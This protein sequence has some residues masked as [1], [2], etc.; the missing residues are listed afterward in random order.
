MSS[1]QTELTLD[2]VALV[3]S[4]LDRASEIYSRMGF[5]LSPRSSHKGSL[6]PDGPVEP[7]GTGNHCAMFATGYLE[8][9][10]ITDKKR[11]SEHVQV[12]LDEYEGLHLIALGCVEAEAEANNIRHRLGKGAEPY[13]VSRDVPMT[14]GSSKQATFN[15]LQLPDESFP[16]ADLFLIEHRNKDVIWQPDMLSQPNGVVGLSEVIV[17]SDDIQ[18]TAGRLSAALGIS[19]TGS[20]DSL[21]FELAR[22]TIKIITRDA[23]GVLFAGIQPPKLPWVAAVEFLTADTGATGKY[24]QENGFKVRKLRDDSVWIDATQADGAVVIFSRAE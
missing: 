19:P 7:W 12:L 13:A 23:L 1:S 15:I 16:E 20:S 8:I 24:L 10:G 4:D 17:C 9:L 11:H 3:V 18:D 14:D 22:G 6:E 21:V 2:H 5:T